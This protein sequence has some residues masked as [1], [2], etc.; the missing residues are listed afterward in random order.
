MVHEMVEARDKRCTVASDPLNSPTL[1]L[2]GGVILTKRTS[3]D[4]WSYPHLRGEIVATA[5]TTGTKQG[6]TSHYGPYGENL[7]TIP[8]NATGNYD[9]AWTGTR[10]TEH[11][12]GL[13][14]TIQMGARLYVPL[15]GRF[16]QTDP[17]EGGSANDYDYAAADPVNLSDHSGLYIMGLNGKEAL[18]CITPSLPLWEG[19]RPNA[20]WYAYTD[21][22]AWAIQIG[23]RYPIGQSNAMRHCVW[24]C[25]L[26]WKMGGDKAQGFLDRH[27][28]KQ[29]GRDHDSDVHNNKQGKSLGAFLRVFYPGIRLR[30]A[31]HW[32]WYMWASLGNMGGL[33]LGDR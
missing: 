8:D 11:A 25:L 3:G 5:D 20:C 26:T 7:A 13:T 6:T 19:S 22:A 32:A 28:W 15:L 33:D 31:A 14:T 16:T 2:P 23:Q 9:I 29:S 21:A 10:N 24:A 18:W 17:I 4:I 27:E 1:T 30:D 12:T